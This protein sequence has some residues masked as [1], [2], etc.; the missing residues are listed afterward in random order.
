MV[1]LR[2]IDVK[3]HHILICSLTSKMDSSVEGGKIVGVFMYFPN[4]IISS[5]TQAN[6]NAQQEN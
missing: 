6:E 3:L 5:V 2:L 1:L 4:Q